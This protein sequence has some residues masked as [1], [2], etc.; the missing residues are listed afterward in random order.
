MSEIDL[1]SLSIRWKTYFPNKCKILAWYTYVRCFT[2][3]FLEWI[4]IIKKYVLSSWCVWKIGLNVESQIIPFPLYLFLDVNVY[5]GGGEALDA[6]RRP[7]VRHGQRLRLVVHAVQPHNLHNL[8]GQCCVCRCKSSGPFYWYNNGR[9]AERTK[10]EKEAGN[11]K[12]K[13]YYK[14]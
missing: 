11:K 2:H 6:L 13:K 4:L 7:G 1:E 8:Q 10:E 12:I 3:L 14:T 9:K 5:S